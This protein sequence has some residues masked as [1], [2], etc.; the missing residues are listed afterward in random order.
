MV[1][2]PD[3]T[4]V[5]LSAEGTNLLSAQGMSLSAQGGMNHISV[6]GVMAATH[7]YGISCRVSNLCT[8]C[9]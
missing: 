2:L 1:G 9:I 3:E 6:A 5:N 4:I 7:K 8:F